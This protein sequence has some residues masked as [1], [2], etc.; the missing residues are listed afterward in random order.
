M[1]CGSGLAALY[2]GVCTGVD[3]LP[4]GWCRR[5]VLLWASWPLRFELRYLEAQGAEH[6][7]V[8]VKCGLHPHRGQRLWETEATASCSLSLPFFIVFV[9]IM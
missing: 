7:R 9:V 6:L 1:G 4:Q 8:R 3:A 2:Q 5:E